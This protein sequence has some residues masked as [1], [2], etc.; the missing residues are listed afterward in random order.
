[1]RTNQLSPVIVS[2]AVATTLVLGL[3]G[4]NRQSEEKTP[5]QRVDAALAKVEQE[6]QTVVGK[7]QQTSKE[8]LAAGKTEIASAAASSPNVLRD[9]KVQL[10]DATITANIKAELALDPA[11]SALQIN[12]DSKEGRVALRGTAPDVAARDRA[13]LLAQRISGV[14]GVDNQLEIRSN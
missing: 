4:C 9:V 1:M 11:L 5:G 7:M 3:G 10:A 13:T 6:T 12:V 8:V 2:M 14:L